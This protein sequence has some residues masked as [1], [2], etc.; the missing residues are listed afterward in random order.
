MSAD[1]KLVLTNAVY[2]NGQW[3]NKF[4]KAD[5]REGTF[6]LLDG[7]TNQTAFMRQ[8]EIFDYTDNENYQAINLPYK[9]ERTS[10]FVVLPKKEKFETVLKDIKNVYRQ[11]LENLTENN[12]NLKMPKFEFTTGVYE[13]KNHFQELGII[14]AF[15]GLADF[16]GISVASKLFIDSILHK[17]FIKVDEKGTKAATA[18]AVIMKDTGEPGNQIEMSIDRPFIFF[19]KDIKSG[20]ILFLSVVK[21]PKV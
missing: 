14:D 2:F 20:Q 21:N 8:V 5:T 18:T 10:M 19:I 4:E 3:V 6:H 17:A 11:A 12:I 1:T 15:G 16:S 9:G 13:L 7:N